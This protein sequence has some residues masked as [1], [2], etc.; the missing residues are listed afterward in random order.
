MS[1]SPNGKD[2]FLETLD[3]IC[4][5][6][7][8]SGIPYMLTGGAAVGFWGH[9]RT[10]MDIDIVIQIR[11]KQVAAF[12][13][14]IGNDVFIDNEEIKKSILN[15]SM[16]NLIYNKTYFKIDIIPLDEDNIY[17]LKKF[18][19]RV[20]IKF[21]NRDIFVIGL[22]DLI[23]SKL[24][25]S[26]SAGGSERQ[27]KDCESIYRLNYEKLDLEYIRKWAKFLK[28]EDEFATL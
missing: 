24:L 20:K 6:L 13:E 14:N 4:K 7:E 23:I 9:I 27:I 8:L 18:E 17:E 26:K 25:W 12:L 28:I 1:E 11:S 19:N 15:R 21:P 16:F 22:E 2:L 5:K 10:T 3:W